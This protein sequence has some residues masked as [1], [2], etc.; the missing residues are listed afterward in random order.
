MN[1]SSMTKVEAHHKILN[2]RTELN[3]HNH[4]YYV[5]DSPIIKDFEFDLLLEELQKLESA[6]PEFQDSNSPTKRVGGT[7]TKNFETVAH[8][9]PMLSLSN[10]YSREEL[11]E[12]FQR[13]TKLL[14]EEIEFVCELKYDGAAIGITYENGFFA[15]AVTRGDGSKGDDIS[16]NV[17]TIA[18][19]PLELK[20]QGFPDSFEIRGEIFMLLDGFKKLNESRLNEGLET[21]ANP[22]NT[23]SGTLKMKDSSVVATRALDSFLYYIFSEEEVAS[24]HYDS[25]VKA[26]DWGFKIPSV[27]NKYI[28]KAKNIEEIFE[29]INYWDEHRH[30][31][32]FEIDGIVIK[33]NN[34]V[35]QQRLGTTA[36]SPRW[37]IA[38]KFKAAE[39]STVLN[40]VS[41]QVGRTGAITPVANLSPVH[42]AGTT[43]K[44]AS[45]HNADQIAKLE[46]RVGDHVF[47]EK[48]GEI[49]PKVTGVDLQFRSINSEE[50]TYAT[51]CP[52]CS[53][54]LVREEG[55]A[56]HY[57][58]NINTCPPQV[59]GRIQH[60]ISRKAMD[61]EG[62]GGETIELLV[63]EG[64]IQNYTDLYK[65]SKEQLLP[66]ERMAEKSVQNIIDG[67]E[68]SKEVP[69]PHVLFGL[70]IRYV[71][72]TVAKKL[73]RHFE[74]MDKLI[75]ASYEELLVVDEIGESIAK[76]FTEFFSIEDNSKLIEE[77]VDAGL[78]MQI[79]KVEGGS[80]SLE[81]LKIV[82]S[83]SFEKFSRTELK[84]LIE[85]HGGKNTGSVSAKTDLIVA[86]EG[87][88]PSKRKKAED[89]GVKIIDENEFAQ[90]IAQ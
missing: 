69:F 12:Y 88:G 10:T 48:G 57:C 89:L 17:K 30:N 47:V 45:L 35:Q 67:I 42:L 75:A 18:T 22:R 6:F 54:E 40:S 1:F 52:E 43:V 38:Y 24:N 25:I 23:A 14:N 34:Y 26:R 5:E 2:L 90:M 59:T 29:F 68:L 21:F 56:Q 62:I 64:L 27:S 83:G 3:D 19:I 41:Y 63:K 70:G 80:Q 13:I 55:E 31:L 32:P 66:L 46:L 37:A 81:G 72:E 39:V 65:L 8:K 28:Q 9:Y 11:E 36:K 15:K 20:G 77:L 87:M 50:F 84:D 74:T 71:G 33:V 7:I 60:F 78:Q 16:A 82:I 44:R 73:A 51:H 61:I 53:T 85:K 4:R 79:E 58:P 86:G 76:S 49:I